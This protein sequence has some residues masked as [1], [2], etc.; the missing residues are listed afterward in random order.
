LFSLSPKLILSTDSLGETFSKAWA[1]V[2][3]SF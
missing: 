1:T 3:K 2:F